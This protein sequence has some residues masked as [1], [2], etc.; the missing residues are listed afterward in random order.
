[1]TEVLIT[2]RVPKELREKMRRSKINWSE[3]LRQ[4]IKSKLEADRKRKA[5]EELER[6]LKG[7]K[8]GYDSLKAIKEARGSG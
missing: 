3:T 2:L 5:E 8:P 1:M 6:L 4:T 7:V